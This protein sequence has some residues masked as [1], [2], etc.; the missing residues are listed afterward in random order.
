MRDKLFI[1]LID[2]FSADWVIATKAQ[3]KNVRQD[4]LATIAK[5]CG[6]KKVILI[7]DGYDVLLTETNIPTRN[8]QRLLKAIPFSLEDQL[9]QDPE[10]Q[11]FSLASNNSNNHQSVA[12]IEQTI[13]DKQL[14]LLQQHN[15]KPEFAVPESLLLP[16][17]FKNSD[18][19]GEVVHWIATIDSNKVI[20]KNGLCSGF[21]LEL[22]HVR[23]LLS[24]CTTDSKTC[25]SKLTL[26]TTG[27]RSSSDSIDPPYNDLLKLAKSKNIESSITCF[28]DST[29]SLFV[30]SF[31]E[32]DCINL[33]QDKAKKHKKRSVH[34]SRWKPAAIAAAA[35]SGLLLVS[36]ILNYQSMSSEYNTLKQEA[37]TL[38]KQTFP[39][40]RRFV[41][42]RQR[43]NTALKQS[44]NSTEQSRYDFIDILGITGNAIN[45]IKSLNLSTINFRNGVLNIHFIVD[46]ANKIDNLEQLLS[47]AGLSSSRGA[48]NKTSN[49]YTGTLRISDK[50]VQ[51]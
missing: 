37:R 9:I 18:T 13:L 19:K 5:K 38:F 33:L 10:N 15:I 46:Q 27:K 16:G 49:G 36:G 24:S 8:K 2:E 25:P 22:E 51:P 32:S 44:G 40:A 17:K 50:G 28:P 23:T 20:I 31:S 21:C 30:R 47:K 42:M 41:K 34:W 6:N 3:Y 29:L 43:M 35:L 39:N 45:K 12:V 11:Y 48:S 14:A 1:R 7:L 26:I 4:S